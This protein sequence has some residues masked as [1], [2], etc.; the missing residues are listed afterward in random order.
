[1]ADRTPRPTPTERF[2]SYNNIRSNPYSDSERILDV[3]DG[4]LDPYTQIAQSAMQNS[5][6]IDSLSAFGNTFRAKILGVVRGK[7]AR[8]LYPELYANSN[9]APNQVPEYFIFSLRDETDQFAPEP[10]RFATTV[11]SYVN[12]IGLQGRAISE[13]PADETIEAFGRGDIVEVYKPEQNSWNGAV[14]RR[15]VV[16][17]NFSA[18]V[19]QGRGAEFYFNISGGQPF[20]SAA[21]AVA[22]SGSFVLVDQPAPSGVVGPQSGVIPY[23]PNATGWVEFLGDPIPQEIIDH[24]ELEDDRGR[25]LS[26]DEATAA[27]LRTDVVRI[28]NAVKQEV[29]SLG[30]LF[31]AGSGKRNPSRG[32]RSF[33][34]LGLALDFQNQVCATSRKPTEI[35]PYLI[36]FDTNVPREL[37]WDEG[38]GPHVPK[39]P[40]VWAKSYLPPESARL[41]PGVKTLIEQPLYYRYY[42]SPEGPGYLIGDDISGYYFNLTE[43]MFKYGFDRIPMK[44][45]LWR[46]APDRDRWGRFEWWHFQ[47]VDGLAPCQTTYGELLQRVWDSHEFIAN[48]TT[49]EDRSRTIQNN[50]RTFSSRCR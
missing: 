43:I 1:M 31:L 29:N 37:W 4:V 50:R 2:G 33:H 45:E 8:H 18:D 36:V 3:R 22:A 21:E 15:V 20:T 39:E 27:H 46:L 6:T 11:Q 30:G 42:G 24:F 10:S 9:V 23:D 44:S 19:L 38:P 7:P 40:I 16:R 41:I 49:S 28:L 17:N 35:D 25:P 14:V 32:S 48:R 12:T 34:P 47:Y 13:K 26:A 5:Y